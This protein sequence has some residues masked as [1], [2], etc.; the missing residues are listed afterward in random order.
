M[1]IAFAEYV[2]PENTW[3]CVVS[4]LALHYIENIERVFQNV[5]RALK[6]GGVFLLNIEHPVFTAGPGQ[7]W[8]YAEDGT[9]RYRPIDQYFF[10]GER[11]TRFLECD[12]LGISFHSHRIDFVQKSA[13][14]DH[15]QPPR[16]SGCPSTI[17][18]IT[19]LHKA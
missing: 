14:S 16:F 17:S 7:D 10:R 12:I 1:H 2:Y 3:D 13:V 6:P 15:L 8:I 5:R 18:S 4:N 19:T 11:H 9:P